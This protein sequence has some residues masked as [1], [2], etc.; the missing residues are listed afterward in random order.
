MSTPKETNGTP[1]TPEQMAN[2]PIQ[3]MTDREIAEETLYWLRQAGAALAQLQS[4]GI[5]SMMSSMMGNMF[6]GGK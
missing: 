6:K 3:N 2:R 1:V 4:G 5:G